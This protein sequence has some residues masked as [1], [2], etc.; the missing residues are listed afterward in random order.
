MPKRPVAIDAELAQAHED[1]HAEYYRSLK[2]APGFEIHDD[3]DIT[4]KVTP[5]AAWSNCGVR[6]RMSTDYCDKRLKQ[7]LLRYRQNGRG[8]GFWIGPA[9][10]PTNLESHLL[11]HGLHCRK[12][13]PAMSFD[14]EKR[15]PRGVQ[16]TTL[17]IKIEPLSDFEIF[18]KH[19]HPSIG[20]LTTKIRKLN[21]ESQRFLLNQKPQTTNF[22]VALLDGIPIG[23]CS[24]FLGSKTA[25]LFDVG[26]L[27]KYRR[28]GVG[29]A[30]VRHA[31]TFARDHNASH[32]TL[33]AT[34]EGFSVYERLGFR[35]IAKFGFWYAAK[36]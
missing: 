3:L 20:P 16:K 9:A 18:Q 10:Q 34:N 11:K 21:L 7:I 30:L 15:F 13:F 28:R 24:S 33:I 26:V 19:P 2:G 4:W 36:P 5:G 1:V 32:V 17:K 14:T 25:S 12:Y 22:F 29:T 31:C 23:I 8:A 6:L 27:E 35:E